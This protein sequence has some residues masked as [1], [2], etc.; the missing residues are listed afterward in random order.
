MSKKNWFVTK[1]Y[2][3]FCHIILKMSQNFRQASF[4]T[5]R[6]CVTGNPFSKQVWIWCY[7]K[8][9]IL[10]F[11]H[12][13]L[14]IP[15]PALPYTSLTCKC[16]SRREKSPHLLYSTA[17]SWACCTALPGQQTADC[18]LHSSPTARQTHGQSHAWNYN[19]IHLCHTN[20]GP[21]NTKPA[22][23]FIMVYL[24]LY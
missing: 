1:Y 22:A 10:T 19:F 20:M 8:A 7:I 9:T 6:H 5:E 24:C 13:S 11:N 12:R 18:Q 3:P 15:K 4:V 16:D 17:V 2:W 21:G 14:D 23:I